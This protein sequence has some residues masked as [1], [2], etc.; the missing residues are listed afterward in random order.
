LRVSGEMALELVYSIY[1]GASSGGGGA[2]DPPP[3]VLSSRD[4]H[5]ICAVVSDLQG[6][7]HFFS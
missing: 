6:L 5:E 7:M 3:P 2:L 1:M 4:V